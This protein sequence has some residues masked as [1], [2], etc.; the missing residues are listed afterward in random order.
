MIADLPEHQ[1]EGPEGIGMWA[2]VEMLGHRRVVGRVSETTLAGD[3]DEPDSRR[4]PGIEPAVVIVTQPRGPQDL[5][6]RCVR[7]AWKPSEID[8]AHLAQGGTIWLSCWGGLPP[9]MLE[10]QAP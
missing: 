4:Q 1:A 5:G 6:M 8:L 10:V 2:V 3:L 9:H 7:V